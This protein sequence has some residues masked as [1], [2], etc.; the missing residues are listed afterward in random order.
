MERKQNSQNKTTNLQ[1]YPIITKILLFFSKD[2]NLALYCLCCSQI[3][4]D[5]GEMCVYV[6]P[7]PQ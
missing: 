5:A 2:K 7:H 1:E 3:M 4:Y 6:T